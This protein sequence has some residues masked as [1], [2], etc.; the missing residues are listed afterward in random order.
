MNF[1]HCAK[2][3]TLKFEKWPNTSLA[4]NFIQI[5]PFIKFC[6]EKIELFD[7]LVLALRI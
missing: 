1:G 3:K 2:K 4:F 7:L 6:I 5:I